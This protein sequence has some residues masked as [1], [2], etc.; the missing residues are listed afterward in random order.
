MTDIELGNI[1]EDRTEQEQAKRT[2]RVEEEDTD[3]IN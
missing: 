1:G 3:L 2:E